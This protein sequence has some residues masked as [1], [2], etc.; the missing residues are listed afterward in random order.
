MAAERAGER[1]RVLAVVG[2]FAALFA[3]VAIRAGQLAVINGGRLARL[4]DRQHRGE[5]ELGGRRGPIVDRAGELLASTVDAQSVYAAPAVLRGEMARFSAIART[6]GVP[7]D[8]LRRK[9]AATGGAEIPFVW[10]KR[11]ATPREVTA[12]AGIGIK[13]V[14]TLPEGRRVYPRASL[15]AHV[16]GFSGIDADGLEGIERQYDAVIRPPGRVLEASRDAHGRHLFTGGMELAEA[17]IGAQV[18]LTLDAGYQAVVERE[19][20]AGVARADA[21]AGTAIVLD[22]WT[23]QVLALANMPTFDPNHVAGSNAAAR[24]NRAITD[25]FE[26][27]STLKMVLAAAALDRDVTTPGARV[28]CERGRYRVGRR[29]IHDHERRGWLTFAD[30]IRYSSNIGAA[31]VA[32]RVGARTLYEYLRAFGFG[33]PTGIGLPGEVGGQ[34]RDVAKWSAID[35]ATASFGQG[36]AVTPIQLATAFAAV[37]NGGVLLRPYVVRRV[38]G[39]DGAVIARQR[40]HE[41]RRVMRRAT[42]RVLATLLRGAVEGDGGTG[43]LARIS[44]VAVAGKT[45]T[46]QKVDPN[47]GRYSPTA[48]V[49]SFVGFVPADAPRF[50][51]LVMIDEPGESPYGGVVAA[52]V[53]RRIATALL[54]RV[55]VEQRS[56]GVFQEVRGGDVVDA[57][58][59]F[60]GPVPRAGPDRPEVRA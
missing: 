29:T 57:V 48:R 25:M 32:E 7:T 60:L 17:P 51:V 27:G 55:G 49:G 18:E 31:K 20:A 43:H 24:R 47:T 54:G 34:L 10:L 11:L 46:S 2:G 14:G 37:A 36:V 56:E 21:R 52:P 8:D 39:A 40:R 4:A 53:F 58:E 9:V 45:G 30:V 15:A 26:P 42:A 1:R 35:L 33:T 28:Y 22:P 23:G 50:V 38:I 16:L 13:G 6:L 44:G 59:D 5:V 19:L 3:V 41:V 12:L